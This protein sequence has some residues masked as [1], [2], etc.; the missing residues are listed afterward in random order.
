MS[1]KIE[2]DADGYLQLLLFREFMP[3]I[4]SRGMHVATVFD[5]IARAVASDSWKLGAT[6]ELIG[7]EGGGAVAFL[8]D[9]ENS[10]SAS[11]LFQKFD[12][13]PAATDDRAARQAEGDRL[14]KLPP[15][16]RLKIA[17]ARAARERGAL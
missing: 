6:G 14:A 15:L 5:L 8:D 12:E 11:H 13:R 2:V 3:H 9:L 1:K 10:Q 16:E 7:S 17:N 4:A